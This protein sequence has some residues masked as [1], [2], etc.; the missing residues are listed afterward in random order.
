MWL[1]R[2]CSEDRSVDFLPS[3]DMCTTLTSFVIAITTQR[4]SCIKALLH[5]KTNRCIHVS[6]LGVT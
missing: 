1:L 2:G 4:S 5:Q 3:H 6:G